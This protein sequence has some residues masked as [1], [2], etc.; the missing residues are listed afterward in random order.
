MSDVVIT[1]LGLALPQAADAE[2]LWNAVSAGT[3]AV[4][5]IERFDSS[6]YSCSQ[7]A[8]LDADTEAATVGTLKVRLRK[9]MDRFCQ[10][11]MSAAGSALDDAG[12]DPE[13]HTEA[14]G[15]YIGNM[16]GGWDIT[17]PSMRGLC[18]HGYPGVSPY[19]ASAWFPTA[20]QGQI[21]I[22][23][24]LKGFSKT[25]VAD[26]AGAALALGYGARAVDEGRADVM[27]A[28][29]AEAPVTPYTY[30]FCSTSGR[31]AS[32]TYRPADARADGF[33]VG[34]GAVLLALERAETARA[35]GATPLARLAGFASRHTPENAVFTAAG[36]TVLAD[37]LDAALT[38]AEIST[39]DFVALD[40]QG[41]ADA[42][43][44]EITAVRS[45]LGDVPMGTA[46]PTTGHLLGAAPAVDAAIAL[47]AIRHGAVP[48]VAGCERPTDPAIITGAPLPR[49]VRTAAIV[50]RG[51]DG[52]VAV[53]VLRAVGE[54]DRKEYR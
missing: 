2:Q 15:A 26:T 25:V 3:S 45:L 47:L 12:L 48:P 44:A 51:A 37:A 22:Q 46:K 27:L 23:W 29:G 42:D 17:E 50:S 19:I 30:T 32:N 8:V 9:R 11:A 34:E 28:G 36:S 4:A 49:E 21:S 18:D 38:E 31:L 1:G 43:K 20:A 13:R 6:R 33:C 53:S 5:P 52:T 54:P 24:G 40:A 7:A 10:L 16:F 14:T 39:V 41:T 35:R